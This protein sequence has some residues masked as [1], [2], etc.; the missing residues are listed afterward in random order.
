MEQH[1]QNLIKSNYSTLAKEIK[2]IPVTGYLMKDHIITD[3]I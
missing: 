1:E 3:E 2:V